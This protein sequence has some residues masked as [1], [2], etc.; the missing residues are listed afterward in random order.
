MALANKKYLAIKPDNG[1]IPAIDNK[2]MVKPIANNGLDLPKPL[3]AE[4]FSE[5]S[6]RVCKYGTKNAYIK[7][8]THAQ[9]SA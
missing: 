5:P 9:P 6:N 8:T 1:G 2:A 3:N 4:I 7:R